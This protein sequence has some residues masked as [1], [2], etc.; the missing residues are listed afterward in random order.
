MVPKQ[1]VN[2]D[3]EVNVDVYQQPDTCF[4]VCECCEAPQPLHASMYARRAD[5][6][7]PPHLQ[8][9]V[10]YV[11]TVPQIYVAQPV[12][13]AQQYQPQ[14]AAQAPQPSSAARVAK[15]VGSALLS[16]GAAAVA[17]GVSIVQQQ[18]VRRTE[19]ETQ[20]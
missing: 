7:P 16:I 12:Q 18:R 20:C 9:A 10:S 3:R 8:Q 2:F 13:P 15:G 17:A 4:P 1:Q 6:P 5:D 14:Q 19:H 11:P